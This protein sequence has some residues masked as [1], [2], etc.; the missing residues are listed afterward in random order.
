MRFV[1]VA[2]VFFHASGALMAL[3]TQAP[4]PIAPAPRV[5]SADL[6]QTRGPMNRMYNFCLGAGRANEG[7]RAEWQRQL[8]RVHAECGFRSIRFHGVF[9]DDMG[10]R[11]EYLKLY[12]TTCAVKSVDAACRVGGPATTG[13]GWIDETLAY[14]AEQKGPLDFISTHSYAT[15]SGYL[16][17]SRGPSPCAKTTSGSSS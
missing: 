12:T 1:A 5:I 2:V 11:A 3:D 15:T 16:D 10:A 17:T 6:A 4:T 9:T 14:C 8:R 7:L 13:E